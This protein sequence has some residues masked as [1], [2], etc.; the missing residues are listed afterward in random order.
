MTRNIAMTA[1][2]LPLLLAACGT[3]QE[4]CIRKHTAEYRNVSNLLSEVEGNLA[5]G[6][7]WE[8]RTVSRTVWGTCRR[9]E[10]GD[11]DEPRMVSTP[12]WR[13][14]TDT[15]R[16]RVAIDPAAESRKRDNLSARKSELTAEAEAYVRACRTAFPEEDSTVTAAPAPSQ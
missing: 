11:D 14:V 6:Y 12:C 3:P 13:D 10:R 7:A 2:A 4:R 5:R 8:E 16:F 9:I 1:I 15:E